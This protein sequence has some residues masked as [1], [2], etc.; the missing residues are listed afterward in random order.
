MAMGRRDAGRQQ[1]LF[2]TADQLPKL[3]GHVFLREAE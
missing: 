2:I 1:D 3:I